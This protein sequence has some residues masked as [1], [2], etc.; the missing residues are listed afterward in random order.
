M[1]EQVSPGREVAQILQSS[2]FQV[3]VQQALP[4]S[5][6]LDR[7][8]RA[9]ITAIQANPGIVEADKSSLY[10]SIVQSALAGLNLD[11]KEA[12][13]VVFNTNVGTKQSPRWI[14]KVQFM[15][16]ISGIIKRLGEAGVAVHSQVVCENDE[17]IFEQGDS[18]SIT[19]R[20]TKLG[21]AKGAMIGAYAICKTKAGEIYR[22]V[23]DKDQIEAVRRQSRAPDSLMWTQFESEGWRKTVIRRCAK[24]I[25]LYDQ[26][27][28]RTL[29]A[30]D[31]TFT[32]DEDIPAV[33]PG[34]VV[35]T[36]QA[37]TPK[38]GGARPAALQAVLDQGAAD[39]VPT[40]EVVQEDIF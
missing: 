40:G 18:P 34:S 11:G 20:P 25:P 7:F 13:L 16:M 24:R 26:L 14:K 39:V 30:D 21:Q 38:N 37:D 2:D 31:K 6:S 4:P 12:A 32:M 5:M 22:E 36:Q 9:V 15:P 17:F 27:A 23:M 1:N 35:S 8:T 29:D 3:K 19:H 28:E 10:S 33:D